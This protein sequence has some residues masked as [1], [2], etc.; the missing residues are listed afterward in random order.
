MRLSSVTLAAALLA[1]AP[2][3]AQQSAPVAPR[4]RGI[5]RFSADFGGDKVLEF[6]YQDGSTPDVTAGG[7]VGLTAGIAYRA[8]RATAGGLDLQAMAGVKYRTI[9]PAKNQ[10][11]TWLRFPVEA[12][13]VWRTPKGFG[14]GAGATAHVGNKLSVSGDA[15][16]GSVKFD[17]TPGAVGQ[18]EWA[19]RNI[20]L[21]LRYTAMNY[22]VSGSGAKVDA[23]N[24]GAGISV[25]FGRGVR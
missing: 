23:S 16:S 18:V 10:D 5:G 20:L 9:P 1:A 11:A 3:A 17:A 13:V 22:T 15:A 6:Q 12:L 25:L 7:G 19:F 4:L 24:I 21:D 14:I 2:L 8:V